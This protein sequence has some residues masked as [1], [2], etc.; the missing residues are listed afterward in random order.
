MLDYFKSVTNLLWICYNMIFPK[1]ESSELACLT[2]FFSSDNTRFM[3]FYLEFVT[4]IMNP[5]LAL[6][7]DDLPVS[8]FEP[9]GYQP[10]GE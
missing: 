5:V 10:I 7:G 1:F 3:L 4:D 9:G 6:E 8:A 2:L